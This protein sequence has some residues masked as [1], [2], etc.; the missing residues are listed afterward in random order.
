MTSS[1]V[2]VKITSLL[3]TRYIIVHDNSKNT[4]SNQLQFFV[5]TLGTLGQGEFEFGFC[6]SVY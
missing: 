3:F 4:G 1:S 2:Y 6:G 5:G